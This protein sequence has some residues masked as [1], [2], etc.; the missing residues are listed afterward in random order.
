[1]PQPVAV[2]AAISWKAFSLS[3][4]EAIVSASSAAA[5]SELIPRRLTSSLSCSRAPCPCTV[6][7][8]PLSFSMNDL[9]EETEQGAYRK[10]VRNCRGRDGIWSIEQEVSI[11]QAMT[12]KRQ[13]KAPP[14]KTDKKS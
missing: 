2:P 8:R 5:A 4:V 7:T 12:Q 14:P 11:A 13:E 9:R 1:M 3:P 10:A 6:P